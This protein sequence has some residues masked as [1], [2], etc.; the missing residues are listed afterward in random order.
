MANHSY[1]AMATFCQ[2]HHFKHSPWNRLAPRRQTILLCRQ[3]VEGRQPEALSETQI[4]PTDAKFV[5]VAE[6]CT[7]LDVVELEVVMEPPE[8][9]VSENRQKQNRFP[10]LNNVLLFAYKCRK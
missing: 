4:T 8:Q 2:T 1:Q 7:P 5:R 3:I 6:R 10:I 9:E